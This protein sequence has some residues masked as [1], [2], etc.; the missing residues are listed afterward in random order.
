MN[1]KE[2]NIDLIV[3]DTAHGHTKSVIDAIKKIKKTFDIELIAGNIAT[4]DAAKSLINAGIDALKVGIGP[5][6]IC[7]TRIIAGVGVPQLTA[8][9]D[10]YSIA[11]KQAIEHAMCKV[12]SKK[13]FSQFHDVAWLC[14]QQ[15][16]A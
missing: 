14:S 10:V 8:V 4:A 9:Q 6:S 1:A 11:K 7:T 15:R 13:R 5:G 3:V 12:V 2:E 16:H